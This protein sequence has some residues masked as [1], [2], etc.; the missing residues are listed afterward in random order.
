MPKVT[1]TVENH[2]IVK[3]DPNV[4]DL[5]PAKEQITWEVVTDK[6]SESCT[7]EILF[8]LEYGVLGPFRHQRGNPHHPARGWYK[9]DGAGTVQSNTA[10][11]PEMKG[12]MWKYDV[13]LHHCGSGREVDRKDPWIRFKDGN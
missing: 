1:I 5:D 12:A 13:V 6:A 10:D 9:V 11:R 7:V 8:W 2:A 4:Q 3:V